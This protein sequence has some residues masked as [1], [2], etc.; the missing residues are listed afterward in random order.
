MSDQTNSVQRNPRPGVTGTVV[1]DKMDKTIIVR[2]DVRVK[3]PLYGK[4]VRRSSKFV[5]HDEQNQARIGDE[6]ELV[7]TRPLSKTKSW[8]LTRVVREAPR[9]ENE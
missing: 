9:G 8:R 5:A 1:S 4:Y 6:V 3:H 2:R 7:Q